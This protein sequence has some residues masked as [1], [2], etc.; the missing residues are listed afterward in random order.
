MTL[1]IVYIYQHLT[2]RTDPESCQQYFFNFSKAIKTC[3][4]VVSDSNWRM[5]YT[6]NMGVIIEHVK[7]P[8]KDIV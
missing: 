6:A 5:V 8:H 2:S 7:F 4:Y 3:I 1:R